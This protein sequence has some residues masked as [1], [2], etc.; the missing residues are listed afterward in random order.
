MGVSGG[1][2]GAL[3]GPAMM[4]G[5][6]PA[7]W[8]RVGPL[9][10]RA[11]AV[12]DSGPC[13]AW[14]GSGGAGHFV[15]MVH[16]GIEYGDMQL[17]AEAWSLLRAA[18]RRPTAMAELFGHWNQGVL[19]SYLMEITSQIVDRRDPKGSGPL[20]DQIADIA[21]QKGTGRWT[22][23]EALQLGVP[24][25]TLT[26]A[27]ETRAL[28]GDSARVPLSLAYG[29]RPLQPPD[30]ADQDLEQALLACKLASYSQGFQLLAAASR[31]Y[32][33]GTDLASVARIWTAGCIIRAGLLE[34]IRHAFGRDPA[35]PVLVL[36]P[37]IGALWANAL[38]GLRRTVAQAALAGVPVPA[39]SASLAWADG[40]CTAHGSAAL[41]Q[42]QRDWF[43]AH[44]YR[45]RDQPDQ[46][47][48]SDWAALP[49]VED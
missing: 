6:D 16:N 12:S 47:I 37:E 41:L 27:V 32:G 5:G 14:C 36:D 20:L 34:A 24:I 10:E 22:A 19:K 7:S 23:V 25:P 8:T 42:A 17:I 43:G 30:I 38:P 13:I 15:K 1:E 44:T 31:S 46:P 21:G 2:Q 26:A 9:L 28:S 18:G 29:P 33:F 3:L 40:L 35:L 48:H 4:P 49:R 11:C 45:R 39:M